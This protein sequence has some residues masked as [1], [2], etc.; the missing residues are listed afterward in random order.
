[1]YLH[2][3]SS[4]KPL[5]IC[6]FVDYICGPSACGAIWGFADP[7]FFAICGFAICWPKFIA[8]LQ[9]RQIWKFFIFLLINSYLKCS[10]SNFYQI[11]NSAKQ[12]CRWLLDSFAI[13]GGNFFKKM[14]NSLCLIVEN[15]RIYNL[16]IVSPTKFADWQF[17]DLQFVDQC[18]E[19]CD[20]AYLRNLRI[21]A[22]A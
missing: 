5:K 12:T 21:F 18:K 22:I 1:M 20:L 6:K 4:P 3:S 8:D 7:I 17:A 16:R 15:L 19:I 13:K 14:F 2:E 11:K 9:F 10:N